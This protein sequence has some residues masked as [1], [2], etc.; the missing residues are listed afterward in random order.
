ML[1]PGIPV[2]WAYVRPRCFYEQK[3]IIFDSETGNLCDILYLHFRS[4][5]QNFTLCFYPK[6]EE[7]DFEKAFRMSWKHIKVLTNSN[8]CFVNIA[9]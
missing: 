3:V 8:V 2:I 1:N 9:V 6:L 4:F 5:L 7:V